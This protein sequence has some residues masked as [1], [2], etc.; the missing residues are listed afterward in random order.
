MAKKTKKAKKRRKPQ[1]DEN[2]MA[3]HVIAQITTSDAARALGKRG[4]MARKANLSDE[5]LTQ[6]GKQGATAR[7]DKARLKLVEKPDVST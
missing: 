5:R 2:Q 7:W 1:K 4:G 3:H 6:I